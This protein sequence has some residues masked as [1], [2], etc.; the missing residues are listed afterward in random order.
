MA[1][2]SFLNSGYE[3]IPVNL[4]I[5][6]ISCSDEEGREIITVW[7]DCTGETLHTV[8]DA[9]EVAYENWREARGPVE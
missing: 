3:I 8:L 5:V 1:Y 4:P 7:E 9:C 6:K 2:Y